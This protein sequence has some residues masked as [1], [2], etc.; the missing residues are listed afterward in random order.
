MRILYRNNLK[1]RD[2][3]KEGSQDLHSER[4]TIAERQGSS[5]NASPEA[6]PTWP[7]TH[8]SGCF[9]TYPNN[10]KNR[11]FGK[12]GLQDLH[13]EREIIAERQGSSENA[14]PEVNPTRPKTDSSSC[15]G[16]NLTKKLKL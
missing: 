7:K 11:D 12:A 6:N 15:F 8:S 5:E 3:G 2:F 10:L 4:E 16:I 1:N 13:S 14:N 9:G